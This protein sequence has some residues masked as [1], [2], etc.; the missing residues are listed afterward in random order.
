MKPRW[1]FRCPMCNTDIFHS[2]VL[3]LAVNDVYLPGTG[4]KPQLPAE[5]LKV[6]CPNC[7]KETLFKRHELVFRT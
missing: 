4:P 7:H 5:G 6:K 3:S 2:K 1:V